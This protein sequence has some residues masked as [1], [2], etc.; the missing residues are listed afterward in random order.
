MSVTALAIASKTRNLLLAALTVLIV[1]ALGAATDPPGAA[2][3]TVSSGPLQADTGS[4]RWRLSF[5]DRRG[6]RVLT[7]DTGRGAG[8]AGT[9]GFRDGSVWRHATRIIGARRLGTGIAA[10]LATN[11][12]LGRRIEV[13]LTPQRPGVIRLRASLSGPSTAATGVTALGIGFDARPAERYLGFGERSNAVDQRG[14][15]V[16]SYVGEGAYPESERPL[17][18][19]FVPPWGFQQRDDAT[20]FP[21]PWLLSTAGYGVLVDNTE[22]SYYRLGDGGDAWSVEVTSAPPDQPQGAG[23]PPPGELSLRIFAGPDPADALRRFTAATGRQPRAAAPWYFGPWFQPS[24]DER[25]QVEALQSADAPV[26]VGQT[27]THY[28]PCG[29]HVGR[30]AEQRARTAWFHSRGLATTTYFNPMIC[31]DYTGAYDEAVERGALTATEA[32]EPYVYHYSTD[33]QF[34]VSQFDF[35]SAAGRGM[36]GE[37]LAEAVAD[38]YDGWMED[39]GEYTPLDSRSANGMD[40]TE[41]HNLYPVQYHCAA[42]DFARSAGRPLGRFIR[43]GYT[44]VAP[45]AP[46]VWGGDPTVG[47]GFDGLA[48][49]LTNGLSM[50][51]SGISTWGSDIGGFFA[52]GANRLTPELLQ[53]W[54]Q[55]GAVSGVM[56][57]QANG[58]ALPAKDRPQVWDAEQIDNWRRYAKLRTSLYP[59]IAA[60][61]ATYRRSGLPIMRHLALVYPGD[62]RATRQDDEFLFGPDLLAAPV[63][64]PGARQRRLY[65]PRGRWIDL[66]RSAS[67]REATGGLVLSGARTAGGR[68]ETTIRAPLDELPLIVRA[69]AVLPLLP[70]DVDTLAAYGGGNGL[71][72]LRDRA[73]QLRLLAFPRGRSTSRFYDDGRIVSIERRGRWTL[74][75]RGNRGRSYDLQA[76][77]GTLKQRLRPCR[78]LL[79]GRRLPASHWRYRAGERVLDA[80]F[81]GASAKLTVVGR[82]QGRCG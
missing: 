27:Y 77:L 41:M 2:A 7:E 33:S 74:R 21:V 50:G 18:S 60:A 70:P 71:V 22:P 42:Q 54:V 79:D 12:P 69:G 38:G 66:W 67:Y 25:S 45:C 59:Y 4:G 26:S 58:I 76:S 19:V 40:G 81:D 3:A 62:R 37:L 34:L 47:W 32:G 1:A 11:D 16:E 65:L 75:I 28:L 8:P 53:R 9:L 64:E 43:S 68:R 20:Y 5:E 82:T 39:F 48:S 23:A 6:H 73:G 44:G 49:A 31:T 52:I 61:E 51:L 30:R 36:F 10:T 46:I 72:R 78:V 80:S 35:S 63:V 17:I 29:D 57:T 55:F 56:R 14:N 13:V 15:V 24:G